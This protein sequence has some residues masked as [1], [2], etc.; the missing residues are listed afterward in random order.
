MCDRRRATGTTRAA[1]REQGAALLVAVLVLALM[2]II[3]LSAMETV[4]R[5]RQV[6]GYQSRAQT[7]LYAAEAGI[8]LAM[9][10]IDDEVSDRAPRGEAG[11]LEWN[12]SVVVPPAT[13]PDFPDQ[14]NAEVLGVDFPAPGSPRF[15]MDPNAADPNDALAPPQAIRYMG[16]GLPCRDW[17]PMSQEQGRNL[18]DW[19]ESL[20]DIRVRGDNPGGTEVSLQ[21]TGAK[22]FAYN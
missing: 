8:S 22:C 12:P 18:P 17:P 7:A 20:W 6:A 1:R 5:D 15:Y 13:E 14:A 11:L 19:R 9:A 3:G 10:M 4:T 2:G 16:K 21:A